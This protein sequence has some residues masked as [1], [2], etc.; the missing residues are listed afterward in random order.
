[1]S[2]QSGNECKCKARCGECL[3]VQ[4]VQWYAMTKQSG[5]KYKARRGKCM[6]AGTVV[7]YEQTVRERVK[8][9]MRR[10]GAG[11]PVPYELTVREGAQ[12][13][14]WCVHASR[15]SGTV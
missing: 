12:G 9:Q 15:N 8:A 6:L 5:N 13:Q 3:R 2:K 14:M 7:H 4:W 10:L 11:K 1:M